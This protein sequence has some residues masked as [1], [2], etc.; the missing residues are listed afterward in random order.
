MAGE[1]HEQMLIRDFEK[2]A[3]ADGRVS[4]HALPRLLEQTT[5]RAPSSDELKAV[6]SK[7][8]R[9]SKKERRLS[10]AA[11]LAVV[12]VQKHFRGTINFQDG[13]SRCLPHPLLQSTE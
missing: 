1:S 3:D 5:G 11:W 2:L 9:V 8:D 7:A 13:L 6:L 12:G 4:E 10:M